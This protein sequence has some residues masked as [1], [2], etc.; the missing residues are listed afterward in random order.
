MCA[1]LELAVYR[2]GKFVGGRATQL[3]NDSVQLHRI[4]AKSQIDSMRK[5][6]GRWFPEL[7]M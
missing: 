1:D 5:N 3:V 2:V 6:Q 4:V 7:T